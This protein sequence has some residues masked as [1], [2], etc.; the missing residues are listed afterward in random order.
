VSVAPLHLVLLGPPGSGKG[1]QAIRLSQALGIPA[2]STGDILRAQLQAASTHGDQLHRYLDRGELV[3]DALVI[4]IIRHRLGDPDTENGFILDGFPRTLTQGEALD[5]MLE[6]LG[7]PIDAVVY[8]AIH[9]TAL[10]ER[11]GHRY[12]SGPVQRADDRPEIVSHRIDVYLAQTAPLIDY[13][14]RGNRLVTVDGEGSPDQVYRAI[15][16]GLDRLGLAGAPAQT[17]AIETE[18]LRLLLLL[19]GAIR[20]LLAGDRQRAEHLMGVTIPPDFGGHEDRPF[21]E[22]QLRRIEQMPQGQAWMVRLI[23]LRRPGTVIGSIGFHGPPAL[24]GRAEIGYTVFKPWRRQGFALEAV[25]ALLEWAAG[26]GAPSVFLSIGPGNA[27][28]LAIARRL[29]FR[30]VGEQEDE[31]DGRELVFELPLRNSRG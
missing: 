19:P 29:G 20:A 26:Q 15:R 28:S 3:P 2:I 4:E 16:A 21:L 22:V 5:L 13:Y 17:T 11:L 18:R 30:Q 10:M 9:P 24:L 1:T 12:G 7:R 31:V 6:G 8:L 27:A 23:L 25:G 14:R